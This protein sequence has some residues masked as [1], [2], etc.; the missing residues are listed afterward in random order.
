MGL[1]IK[2]FNIINIFRGVHKKPIYRGELPKK[3]GLGQFADLRG[4][5]QKRGGVFLSGGLIPQFT[6]CSCSI[7][8][9]AAVKYLC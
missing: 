7:Q 1:R 5:W 9:V 3:G 2:N 8:S 6:L 4:A